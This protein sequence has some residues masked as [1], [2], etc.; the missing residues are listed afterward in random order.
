MRKNE[1]LLVKADENI[2]VADL[3]IKE[4]YPAIA[5]S[6]TYYAMFYITEVLLYSKGLSFSSHTAVIAAYGKE[7]A[8]TRLL[9]PEHHRRLKEVFESG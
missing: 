7:F 5:L 6:R 1:L 8:K 3:L 9:N 4:G 2:E